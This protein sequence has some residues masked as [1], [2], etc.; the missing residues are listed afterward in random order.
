MSR[1][2]AFDRRHQER[3]RV[4]AAETERWDAL[5]RH[6]C[7]ARSIAGAQQGSSQPRHHGLRPRSAVPRRSLGGAELQ[8][9]RPKRTSTS[10][11]LHHGT[12]SI[13]GPTRALQSAVLL[14]AW[15]MYSHANQ[16]RYLRLYT[17]TYSTR[18]DSL[19][20]WCL[21]RR[22]SMSWVVPLMPRY[23]CCPARSAVRQPKHPGWLG[24]C[25]DGTPAGRAATVRDARRRGP[26]CGCQFRGGLLC[27]QQRSQTSRPRHCCAC[28]GRHRRTG[29]PPEPEC[30]GVEAWL[31]PD[32]GSGSSRL[33]QSLL[34]LICSRD[35]RRSRQARIRRSGDQLPIGCRGAAGPGRPG[36]P[37]DRRGDRRQHQA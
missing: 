6:R 21:R 10:A 18:V 13:R 5:A 12:S 1:R 3:L 17:R 7:G 16:G 32:A 29:L 28:A 11:Q 9:P 20:S 35:H 15:S 30:A 25:H 2:A 34:C 4:V 37:S 14:I 19:S 26:V 31:D 24:R 36:R 33:Q 8:R 23:C 22:D 27:R